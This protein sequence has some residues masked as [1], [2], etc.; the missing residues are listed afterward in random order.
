M[1]W[2]RSIPPTD[3]EP[4]G[5]PV[6]RLLER[7][8]A[9][10]LRPATLRASTGTPSSPRPRPRWSPSPSRRPSSA[11]PAPGSA[12][13]A[14]SSM[15][16]TD[17]RPSSVECATLSSCAAHRVVDLLARG[18]RAPS[19]R[20]TT[21]R[22]ASAAPGRPSGSCLRADSM[23]SGSS[24]GHACIWVKGCQTWRAVQ[25]QQ[26]LVAAQSARRGSI[27]RA[28][29]APDRGARR[30]G[31]RRG[32]SAGGSSPRA[33]WAGGWPSPAGPARAACARRRR[34]ASGVPSTT[35]KMAERA[36]AGSP[37]ARRP[38]AKRR[39]LRHSR[40]RSAG[41]RSHHLHRRLGGGAERRRAARWRTRAGAPG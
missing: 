14:A 37:S 39:M 38:A 7:R 16:G 3:T 32:R 18:A 34:R 8:E 12:S 40:S 23:T 41:I 26:R 20:A 27:P 6:V 28:P 10:L 25:L 15:D 5:V 11:P 2:N 17:A 22:R 33:R 35:G 19:P 24:S 30:C 1:P 21:R 4:D 29:R 13:F 31:R 36:C 9:P